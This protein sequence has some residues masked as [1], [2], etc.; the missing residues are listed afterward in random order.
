M[1]PGEVLLAVFCY[2]LVAVCV[3][4]T[5]AL[6]G[7]ACV[8][9]VVGAGWIV[10]TFK[11][12][13]DTDEHQ[14]RGRNGELVTVKHFPGGQVGTYPTPAVNPG[15]TLNGRPDTRVPDVDEIL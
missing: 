6:C 7:V 12:D 14:T 4:F 15:P 9:F 1:T 8:A 13:P 3:A 2:C 11:G 5:L 10:A